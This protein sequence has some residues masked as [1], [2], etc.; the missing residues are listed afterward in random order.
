MDDSSKIYL[1]YFF[2]LAGFVTLLTVIIV[3]NASGKKLSAHD[4]SLQITLPSSIAIVL[5]GI[6]FIGLNWNNTDEN[7]W[8]YMIVTTIVG[9]MGISLTAIMMSLNRMYWATPT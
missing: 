8:F 2:M 1:F 6:A 4:Y 3:P 5:I 7:R 9:G